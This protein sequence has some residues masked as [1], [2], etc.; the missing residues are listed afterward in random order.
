MD[1]ILNKHCI[2]IITTNINSIVLLALSVSANKLTVVISKKR[3]CDKQRKGERKKE[4]SFLPP[5]S[6]SLS[7]SLTYS[8]HLPEK[9][10]KNE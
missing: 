1:S 8:F 9:Q 10:R 3:I 2:Y 6:L 4:G 7:L 5:L